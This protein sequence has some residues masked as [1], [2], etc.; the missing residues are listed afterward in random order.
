MFLPIERSNKASIVPTVESLEFL[1][2][3][4]K[5]A[6]GGFYFAFYGLDCFLCLRLNREDGAEVLALR[7]NFSVFSAVG[8]VPNRNLDGLRLVF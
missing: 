7:F 2:I 1:A 5:G 6:E 4:D 3:V 8:F